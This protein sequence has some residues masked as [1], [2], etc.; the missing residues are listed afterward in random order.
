MPVLEM[1]GLDLAGKRVLIRQDLNVPVSNGV[2]SSDQRI[3]A[4][5][6][7]IRHCID[8]GAR[9]MIMSHLGRPEE[10]SP[11]AQFSLQPVAD[12]MGD[13]LGKDVPLISNYLEQAPALVDGE[14]VLLEN[15]RFNSGEKADAEDLS[16]QYAALCDIFVM[17]AF[18]TAHR[19]QSS[20][21]GAGQFAPLACAGPLLAAE[22]DALGKALNKPSSPVVAI[23]GGSKVSTKLTVLESLSTIVDQLIPGGGIAN[24][25]IAAAGF[26]VGKSLVELDLIPE[27][28]RLMQ[29][30]QAQGRDIPIPVDVVCGKEFSATAEAVVKPVAEVE[31]D[32]MI[33]DIGPQTANRF[34]EILQQ[35]A[36]IVW[37]GPVG[38]FEFDQFGEGTRV[39]S[40]AIAAS[41]AFSIAGGGD[42]LAAVDKY[43]IADQVSYISTG[44]GAFLEFLE[45]KQLP[46]VA[47]LEARYEDYARGKA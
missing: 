20:T 21:H 17:D 25:F 44:G 34:A 22:L 15:V 5:L 12:Y 29:Q 32:D 37:N 23:V 9:L 31:D 38:V 13:A 28:K 7:T 40:Q 36:T 33:F 4:S 35:A 10:G 16:K 24:T 19:A 2:V 6:P 45:G 46:A 18:G 14:V 47:M 43:G 3:K 1:T 39:L 11:E 27:A 8:A 26:N 30:A 41:A 42:T